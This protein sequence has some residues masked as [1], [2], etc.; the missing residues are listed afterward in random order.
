MH[1]LIISF[2]TEDFVMSRS[3]D[4]SS[5]SNGDI[6]FYVPSGDDGITNAQLLMVKQVH[7]DPAP[8]NKASVQSFV[9]TE[10]KFSDQ[11]AA[12][13]LY[14]KVDPGS[15]YLEVA[16]A[17]LRLLNEPDL[18]NAFV[19]NPKV[20][21]ASLLCSYCP[22]AMSNADQPEQIVVTKP[23]LQEPDWSV[24]INGELIYDNTLSE[25]ITAI[26]NEVVNKH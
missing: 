17:F 9:E 2:N 14:G 13:R 21:F 23:S 25:L 19:R 26:E 18:K 24:E 11:V 16:I 10:P 7:T 4:Q 8:P 20:A 12:K 5:W 22:V 1:L 15:S 3:T 6:S